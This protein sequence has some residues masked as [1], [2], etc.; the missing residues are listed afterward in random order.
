MP[1]RKRDSDLG[2]TNDLERALAK[3]NRT[4]ADGLGAIAE[5]LKPHPTNAADL[6]LSVTGAVGRRSSMAVK[7]VPPLTLSDVERVELS[8]APKLA[9]GSDDPGPF[10]WTS[11][12]PSLAQVVGEAAD[13]SPDPAATSPTGAK[14]WVLTPA[15]PGVVTITATSAS[16]N[17]DGN[18][19]ELTL[20]EGRS[21]SVNLSAGSPVPDTA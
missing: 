3:I 1:A 2:L 10:S 14:V 17:V 15:G 16:P 4:L 20:T 11:S 9:D 13:G 19:I 7:P 5:S 12:D 21:G 8:L 6:R 18:S